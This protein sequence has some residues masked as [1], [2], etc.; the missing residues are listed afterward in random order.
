MLK[1]D[2]WIREMCRKGKMIVP[3]VEGLVAKGKVS[4][5]LSSYGYDIRVAD[6][7]K[8]FTDV[9]NCVVDPKSF[10]NKSFKVWLPSFL[11]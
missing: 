10:N 2:A 9:H 3:F 6:E 7:Y 1:S 5:G 8:V 11:K 4:Y